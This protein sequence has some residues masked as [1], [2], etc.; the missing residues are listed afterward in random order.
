M[1]GSE[2]EILFYARR[3]SATGYLYAYSLT[4]EQKYAATMQQEAIATVCRS[5]ARLAA[6]WPALTTQL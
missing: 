2:P 5:S 6:L 1:L 4:E 3:R